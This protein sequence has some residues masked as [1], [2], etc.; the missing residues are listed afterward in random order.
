MNVHYKN[1]RCIISCIIIS[2]SYT[3]HLVRARLGFCIFH[4]FLPPNVRGKKTI[5]CCWDRSEIQLL[6]QRTLLIRLI[7]Q[8]MT[9]LKSR[10]SPCCLSQCHIFC[11]SYSFCSSASSEAAFCRCL[12]RLLGPLLQIK[13]VPR[14]EDYQVQVYIKR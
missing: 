12:N 1:F 7:D 6:Y 13:G 14:M 8:D 10:I 5:G 11:V 4:I 9:T 2:V 3:L